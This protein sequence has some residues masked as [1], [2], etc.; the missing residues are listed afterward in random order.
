[1][2]Q[3]MWDKVKEILEYSNKISNKY[4][5]HNKEETYKFEEEIYRYLNSI[6]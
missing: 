5:H 6:I 4:N 2:K 3:Q 1:M